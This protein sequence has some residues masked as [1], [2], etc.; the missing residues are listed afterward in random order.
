[1]P[2]M[3]RL[4][5][6]SVQVSRRSTTVISQSPSGS[7]AIM[8]PVVACR[9]DPMT[10]KEQ[11]RE[12]AR[13]SQAQYKIMWGIEDL[14]AGDVLQILATPKTPPRWVGKKFSLANLSDNTL[15][16]RNSYQTAHL[17]QTKVP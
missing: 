13:S 5:I 2:S 1:M 8:I 7:V 12:I 10:S 4:Y 16:E 14:R 15:S 17:V 6:H 11:D 9:L 3:A